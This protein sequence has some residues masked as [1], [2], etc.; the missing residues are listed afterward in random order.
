MVWVILLAGGAGVRL[1]RESVRRYGYPRPKQYCDYGGGTLLELTLARARRFAPDRRIVV[2]TTRPHRGD[3]L[4]VM[5]RHPQVVHL[6][7]PRNRDT[8]SGILLPLLHVR[9]IDPDA[10]IIVMPTDHA[11]AAPGVFS[12]AVLEGLQVVREGG[13]RIALLAAEPSGLDEDYGWV[14]PAAGGG[15]WPRVAR[16][17]EKP[18]RDEL[19]GLREAHALVNTFVLVARS[20]TLERAFACWTPDCLETVLAARR[21]PALFDVAFDLLADSSFSHDVL[22]HI[23]EQLRIVPLAKSAGWSDIGTPA[24]LAQAGW[25]TADAALREPDLARYGDNAV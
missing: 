21:D 16:F 15:R 17:R 3:A 22:E 8:T 24:R 20:A 4:E 11:I 13:D 10:I 7:Q 19:V 1:A 6:E 25:G 2:I 9:A 12:A 14:V 5:K 23:P 18:A